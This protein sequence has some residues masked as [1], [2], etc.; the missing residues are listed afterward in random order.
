MDKMI[1]F[2][3]RAFSVKRGGGSMMRD[4]I[5]SAVRL[6]LPDELAAAHVAMVNADMRVPTKYCISKSRLIVVGALMLWK[7]GLRIA[8]PRCATCWP[9]AARKPSII[10]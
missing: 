9:T 6:A 7:Y 10:G 1:S 2:L 4:V 8:H 3:M 5:V